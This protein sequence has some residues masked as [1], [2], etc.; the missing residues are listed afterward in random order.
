MLFGTVPFLESSILPREIRRSFGASLSAERFFHHEVARFSPPN[1]LG[2]GD[3]SVRYR[4]DLDDALTG[5]P[6][7]RR[8]GLLSVVAC[9]RL[10]IPPRV[11]GGDA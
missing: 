9:L 4:D 7:V 11:R 1:L 2:D 3:L 10:A 5:R 6:E 8:T